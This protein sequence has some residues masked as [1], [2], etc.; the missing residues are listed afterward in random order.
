[1]DEKGGSG[2]VHFA[3]EQVQEHD[4]EIQ[5]RYSGTSR[6]DIHLGFLQVN[7]HYSVKFNIKDDLGEDVDF[8]PLQSL[9]AKIA[10]VIPT[11]EANGHNVTLDFHAHKEKLMQ[12]RLEL[13]SH[14]NPLEQMSLVLHARVLGKGKGT[15]ALKNGVRCIHVDY[16]ADSDAHSDWQGFD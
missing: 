11:D 4:L 9:H 12:E 8:N 10:T 16:D 5:L 7:H 15:P 13:R 2:H 3:A 1:M 6:I 14:N